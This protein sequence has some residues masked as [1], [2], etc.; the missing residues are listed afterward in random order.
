M[1]YALG[2]VK[3][4]L[5]VLGEVGVDVTLQSKLKFRCEE[6]LSNCKEN[7]EQNLFE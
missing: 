2:E 4:E 1:L 5:G 3:N 6:R 7:A